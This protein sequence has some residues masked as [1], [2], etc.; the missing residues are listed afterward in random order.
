MARA[1]ARSS[2]AGLLR[3]A[4]AAVG[5]RPDPWQHQALASVSRRLVL[6]A[7]RQLGKGSVAA[8]K[9]LHLAAFAPERLVLIVSATERQ[10]RIVLGRIRGMLPYVGD[11][12]D[13]AEDTQTEIRFRN[14]SRIVVLP[15]SSTSLRGWTAH[16]LVVDEG[17]YVPRASWEAVVPTTAATGGDIW[18]LTSAGAPAGWLYE[19]AT[20]EDTYP[21]WERHR[22]TAW[23]VPRID[24]EFLES[25]QRRLPRAVFQR[26]YE[27][28]FTGAEDGVFDPAAVA[29]AFRP[30]TRPTDLD[31][32][33]TAVLLGQEESNP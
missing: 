23:Q 25:E 30:S 6:V 5:A 26:E 8:A 19:I 22:V 20:D 9:A 31:L 4:L 2:P 32:D 15:A 28:E 12:A 3:V 21:E 29:G 33:L 27:C 1:A 7:A 13:G 18:C 24:R 14:G 16:L 10:A 17:A 11:A